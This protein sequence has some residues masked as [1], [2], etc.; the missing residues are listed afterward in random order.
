[1]CCSTSL[2]LFSPPLSFSSRYEYLVR[3][4]H[5]NKQFLFHFQVIE[6]FVFVRVFSLF[7]KFLLVLTTLYCNL[8]WAAKFLLNSRIV[9]QVAELPFPLRL[10][11]HS[12]LQ[13]LPGWGVTVLKSLSLGLQWCWVYSANESHQFVLVHICLCNPVLGY[14]HPFREMA[15][16]EQCKLTI[17]STFKFIPFALSCE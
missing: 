9:P 2:V 7:N 11:H 6:S 5:T 1:M 17:Q 16:A 13:P 10:S 3:E 12:D 14:L 15:E 8:I 4:G